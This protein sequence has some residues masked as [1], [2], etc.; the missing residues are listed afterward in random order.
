MTRPWLNDGKGQTPKWQ[1]T[2]KTFHYFV[3][4]TH[5]A[6]KTQST[7]LLSKSLSYFTAQLSSFTYIVNVC[8][9]ECEREINEA[10]YWDFIPN[11]TH[12]LNFLAW[13]QGEPVVLHCTYW[14][15][16]IKT[17]FNNDLTPTSYN[18]RQYLYWPYSNKLLLMSISMKNQHTIFTECCPCMTL[19]EQKKRGLLIMN[20]KQIQNAAFAYFQPSWNDIFHETQQVAENF[21]MLERGWG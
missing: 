11:L 6:L 8:V 10:E 9:C 18:S 17:I 3:C 7:G 1:M 20:Y 16:K 21:A 12:F 5:L 14:K 15:R 2:S 19:V 4:S 13:K